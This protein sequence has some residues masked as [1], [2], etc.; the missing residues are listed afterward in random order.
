MKLFA[1]FKPLAGYFSNF[2]DQIRDYSK[3]GYD[4]LANIPISVCILL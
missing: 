2:N 1:K 3:L 4:F